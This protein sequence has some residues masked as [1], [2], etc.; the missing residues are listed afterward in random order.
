MT[1]FKVGYSILNA[2][3]KLGTPLSGYYIHRYA[4]GFVNDLTVS[5]IAVN[6]NDKTIAIIS[7]DHCICTNDFLN[8][9]INNCIIC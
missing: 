9:I 6:K 8:R 2:N 5:T 4:S 3:P 7:I 1:N